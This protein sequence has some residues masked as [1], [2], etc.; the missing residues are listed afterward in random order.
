MC[1]VFLVLTRLKVLFAL[2]S[3]FRDSFLRLRRCFRAFFDHWV[4]SRAANA[5][6]WGSPRSF[7][8]TL[9]R[10]CWRANLAQNPPHRPPHLPQARR[11]LLALLDQALPRLTALGARV[12]VLAPALIG[13]IDPDSFGRGIGC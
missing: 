6:A 10:A 13:I 8:T 3:L 12:A 11:T 1:K 4:T 5:G 9:G 2:D 7:S